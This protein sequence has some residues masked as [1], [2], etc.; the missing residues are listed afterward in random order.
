MS[1]IKAEDI[2]PRELLR[3]LQQYAD[4][5]CIYIPR[6]AENRQSRGCSPAYREELRQRNQQIRHDRRMGLTTRQLSEKYHLSEKS[7]SRILREGNN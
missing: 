7:I 2:L 3:Q 4:G 6:K 5:T 1:Y